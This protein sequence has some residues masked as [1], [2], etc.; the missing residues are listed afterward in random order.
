MTQASVPRVLPQYIDA[1]KVAQQGGELKGSVPVD[2]LERLLQTLTGYHN[3]ITV[4]LFLEFDDQKRTTVTG[5]LEVDVELQC[6]RCL[7]NTTY[8]VSISV[9]VAIV[10]TEEQVKMLPRTIDPWLVT[11]A[12]ADL[13]GLIEDEI[14]LALP[15][16]AYHPEPCIDKSLYTSSDDNINSGCE[17]ESENPFSVLEQL[18]GSPRK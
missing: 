12:N 17:E 13:Y 8:P 10:S 16:V 11:E 2:A 14:L 5:S 6:Q 7:A 15:M 4:D 9:N 1:R 18:K 3:A